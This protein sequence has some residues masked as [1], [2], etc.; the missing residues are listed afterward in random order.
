MYHRQWESLYIAEFSKH[1][2]TKLVTTTGQFI[3]RF[4]SKRTA[5]SWLSRP[6]CLALYA[7]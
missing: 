1:Y 6:Y 7:C 4:G 2:N 3:T 5:P